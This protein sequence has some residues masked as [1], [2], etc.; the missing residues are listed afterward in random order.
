M[1]FAQ[2]IDN[3]PAPFWK[4]FGMAMLVFL[5]A[6]GTA[7]SI[8]AALRKPDAT[9]IN[10]EPP[11]KFEKM[12]RRFNHD[13]SESRYLDHQ[14]RLDAHDEE[15]EKI[16]LT[17]RAEDKEIRADVANKFESISRALGRIEG[18]LQGDDTN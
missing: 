14:H 13:L 12:S 8:Y 5:G 4:Y 15:I 10:D 3:I 1:L 7:V 11:V 18:K 6:L 16:W 9:R 17:M 2:A